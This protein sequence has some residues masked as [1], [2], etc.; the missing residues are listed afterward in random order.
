MK[1]QKLTRVQLLLVILLLL[2][3][4]VFVLVSSVPAL[5]NSLL[6]YAAANAVFFLEG[7]ALLLSR[8]RSM[9]HE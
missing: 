3:F 8:R 1:K 9:R 2:S 7:V 6:F 5:R 4:A